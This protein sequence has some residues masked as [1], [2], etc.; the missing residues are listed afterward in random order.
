[1]G[2][3]ASV[4]K[5]EPKKFELSSAAQMGIFAL[6][7][8]GALT[9]IAGFFADA[10][11]VWHSYLT[12]YFYFASLAMGGLFFTAI[13]HAAN[14]GWSVT[15][16]RIPEAMTAFL[17]VV[18]IGAIGVLIGGSSLYIWLDHDIVAKDAVL[19]GKS[20]Y[21]NMGFFAIRLLLFTAAW[22]F[23]ASKIVGKSIN[24]DKDG[25]H[26]WTLSNVPWSIGFLVF[27]ALSYSLFSV[28]LMMSLEPHWFS[29]I[30]GV[31]CFAGLFQSALA[32]MI[33]MVLFVRSKGWV[34]GLMTIEH[35]HDLA[36]FLKGFTVF[37]AY[38]AF[39]QFMLIWYANLPEETV[40]FMHRSQHGWAAVSMALIIF[41][42]VVPFVALLPRWAKRTPGHLI[43][44]CI[45]VLVMQY[46]DIFWMVYPNYKEGVHF[47]W[48][49]VGVFLGFL[50]LFLFAIVQFFK[51]F[52]LVPLKDP[53]VH[54]SLS[55][56][57]TY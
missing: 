22:I 56:H 12:S 4:E 48:M 41:K 33:L 55:H 23:F 9:L 7:A 47:S 38:I 19:Q 10:E 2:H 42:F 30:F 6:I 13:Q 17:P 27:F 25:D 37:W 57:V 14:A 36:K 28:D 53:R 29:T 45:L 50:G 40:F 31:Y 35:V 32:F 26:K 49:E 3:S 1:M 18:F 24:Q 20:S 51:R 21:L 39:S 34:T 8:I 16:R 52:P 15:I 43:A 11:R 54:E 5:V 44:V 46:V